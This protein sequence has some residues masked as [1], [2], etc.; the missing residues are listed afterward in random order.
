MGHYGIVI[1]R[2]TGVLRWTLN[3]L[4]AFFGVSQ[5]F[6]IPLTT[7][8]RQMFIRQERHDRE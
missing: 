6:G 4:K 3:L 8:R 2:R 5:P 7:E 1:G